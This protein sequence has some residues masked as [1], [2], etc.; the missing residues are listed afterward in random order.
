MTLLCNGEKVFPLVE[1]LGLEKMC[2]LPLMDLWMT[3]SICFPG[4]KQCI[5]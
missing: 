4:E 2:Y 3:F 5:V 1:I